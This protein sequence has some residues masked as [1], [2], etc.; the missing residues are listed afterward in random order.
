MLGLMKSDKSWKAVIGQRVCTNYSK[1]REIQ[2]GL[3]VQCPSLCPLSSEMRILLSSRY[4]KGTSH[5]RIL[6]PALKEGQKVLLYMPFLNSFNMKY[7][8]CQ[9]AIFG[10]QHV[11]NLINDKPN[12]ILKMFSNHSVPDLVKVLK[13][14]WKTVFSQRLKIVCSIRK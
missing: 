1:L 14:R 13:Y 3:F 8:I 6:S 11:P 2:Q 4:R 10:G 9:D 7:L 12:V 5:R